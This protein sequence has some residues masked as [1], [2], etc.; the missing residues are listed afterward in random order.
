M[1][2]FLKSVQTFFALKC[3]HE[4]SSLTVFWKVELDCSLSDHGDHCGWAKQMLPGNSVGEAD[5]LK[6]SAVRRVE[7]LS[8]PPKT[9][10]TPFM[11]HASGTLRA[12]VIDGSSCHR[13]WPLLSMCTFLDEWIPA[14]PKASNRPVTTASVWVT[15]GS[16][17][18]RDGRS[19]LRP[20]DVS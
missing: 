19:L 3:S 17:P 11:V 4:F 12:V 5:Y 9:Y 16:L 18:G 1:K 20:D 6:H 13:W 7:E 2:V 15:A 14:F 8:Y 10:R